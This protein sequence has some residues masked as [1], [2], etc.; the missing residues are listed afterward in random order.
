[1]QS[2]MFK[3]SPY[4]QEEDKSLKKNEFSTRPAGYG[5]NGEHPNNFKE[6]S[7]LWSRTKTEEFAW[8][9]IFET[10]KNKIRKAEQHLTYGF[11]IRCIKK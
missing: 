4:W 10:N 1:M 3:D 2:Q 8:T 7:I 11:S 9:V 5:N 6:S